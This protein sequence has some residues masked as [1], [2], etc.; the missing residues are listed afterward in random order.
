MAKKLKQITTEPIQPER[1][2]LVIV[3]GSTYEANTLLKQTA[4]FLI[5]Q[6]VRVYLP[7]QR[8]YNSIDSTQ[9]NNP[10]RFW[11]PGSVTV[12]TIY[13]AKGQE[14]DFVY[15]VALDRIAAED[16]IYLRHQLLVALTRTR[17][18]V[19]ISG[20]GDYP[21]YRELDKLIQQEQ[22]I[23]F[24]VTS[25]PQ[26]ELRISDRANLIQGYALGRRNFRHANLSH[27]D[28]SQLHLA[29][30]N[31]IDANLSHANLSGTNLTNAK[32]I[33]ANLSHAN[34]SNANLTNTK[35]MGADLTD[36]NLTGANLDRARV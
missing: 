10:N 15:L 14:A 5:N 17:A 7:S 30:I 36:T 24:T 20:I 28:L 9:Q 2:I 32:L 25:Q 21:L 33:A 23:T 31:L 29:K 3:L 4:T 12:S 1:A 26:R 18:W 27:A 19:N 8:T 6:G 22:T 16:N 13:R 35:L 34:L 11:H